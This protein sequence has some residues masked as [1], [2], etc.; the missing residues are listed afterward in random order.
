M[1]IQPSIASF[2]RMSSIPIVEDMTDDAILMRRI[3]EREQAALSDL[4]DRF[5]AR[6]YGLAMRILDNSTLAE[7]V[8]QDTFLKVWDQATRW[9]AERGKLSTW[10]L[11]LTRYTAI[12]RLRSERRQ[13][14]MNP[15]DLDEMSNLIGQASVVDQPDWLS[16]E[17]IGNLMKALPVDQVEAIQLAFFKGMSH[18]EISDYLNQPLGTVKSR[19]RQ[20]LITLRA[21]WIQ[22]GT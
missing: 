7:E 3:I 1:L 13:A 18:T 17:A 5:A 6:V 9:D 22:T 11:T 10:L 8:T 4:Y 14:P 21:L 16:G 2:Q 15:L 19:I 12:D 20:G